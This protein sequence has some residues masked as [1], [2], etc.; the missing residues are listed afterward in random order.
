MNGTADFV[1]HSPGFTRF[2]MVWPFA[3]PAFHESRDVAW[4]IFKAL[5]APQSGELPELYKDGYPTMDV[6]GGIALFGEPRDV[7]LDG[8]SQPRAANAVDGLGFEEIVF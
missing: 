1:G 6:A 4:Q 3:E 8:F 2:A 7:S 5:R